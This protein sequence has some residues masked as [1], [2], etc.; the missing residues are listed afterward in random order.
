M[1]GLMV[2]VHMYDNAVRERTEAQTEN[3][4]LRA[5]IDNAYAAAQ[6]MSHDDHQ[7]LV[8]VIEALEPALSREDT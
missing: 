4:R 2:P 7:A 5:V 1:G 3:Q 6:E 8:C